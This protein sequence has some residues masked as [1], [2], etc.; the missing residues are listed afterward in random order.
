MPGQRLRLIACEVFTRELCHAIAHSRNE[1]DSE[2][3][4]KGLHSIG[5]AKMRSRIQERIDAV[6]EGRYAAICLGFGLCNNGLADLRAR[7]TPLVL[8]RAHDCITLFL[9]SRERYRREFESE[10]GSYFLTSGWIERGDTDDQLVPE[11]VEHRTG[12]D[13]SYQELVDK[14]GEENA[15]FLAEQLH[16]TK[17]YGRYCY[18]EMGVEPDDRYQRETERRAAERGWRCDHRTGDMR[19][20]SALLDGPWD[21]DFIVIRPGQRVAACH[22]HRVVE[23]RP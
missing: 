2:F 7:H 22:D 19:L 3:L 5:C 8:P 10:P 13:M 23:P 11:S 18:I 21:D 12:M 4:P 9:G 20:I 1:V 17:N 14:Y 15:S 6:P 16:Q